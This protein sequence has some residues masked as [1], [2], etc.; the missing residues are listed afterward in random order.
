M[1]RNKMGI[2]TANGRNPNIDEM[3]RLGAD[4]YT[5]IYEAQGMEQARA[6]RSSY[7]D[8]LILM[9]HYLANWPAHDPIEWADY[10]ANKYEEYSGITRHVTF[11]N[12]QNLEAEG[13]GDTKEWYEAINKWNKVVILKLR[14]K[15]PAMVI[16]APA[17]AYGNRDDEDLEG[18][19]WT[20]Y[21]ICRECIEMCDILNH[22]PYWKPGG[23]G[24]FSKWYGLR[25][26][27]AREFFLDMPIFLDEAGNFASDDSDF[28]D[29]IERY[30]RKLYEYPYILGVTFFIWAD[31]TGTNVVNSWQRARHLSSLVTRLR[32]ADFPKVEPGEVPK[33]KR[34][35]DYPRPENGSWRGI[36]GSAECHHRWA[37]RP[38]GRNRWL[39]LIQS[40]KIGWYKVLDDGS[41]DSIPLIELLRGQGMM[42]IVRLFRGSTFPPPL[43]PKWKET[44]KR[45]VNAGAPY[46]EAVN[47]PRHEDKPDGLETVVDNFIHNADLIHEA[48]GIPLFPSIGI[49]HM[50]GIFKMIAAKG[51]R[52]IFERGAGVAIHNYTLNHPLNYPYDA[53]NKEGRPLTDEEW[54]LGE[55]AWRRRSRE[56]INAQRERDKNP[57]ATYLDDIHNW[58]GFQAAHAALRAAFGDL[59]DDIPIFTTEGGPEVGDGQDGRYPH[60]TP[61]IHQEVV[62]AI[63]KMMQVHRFLPELFPDGVPEELEEPFPWYFAHCHWLIADRE[64]GHDGGWEP[65]A[66][67]GHYWDAQFGLHG[68]LP[69]VEALA[70]LPL[71]PEEEVALV[72]G[73]FEGGFR[74][75]GA[76]EVI[77]AYGWEPWWDTNKPTDVPNP[78]EPGYNRRPEFKPDV[79]RPPSGTCQK[80][81]NTHATHNAGLYQQVA[82]F[83][84]LSRTVPQG[85]SELGR[86]GRKVTFR[87]KAYVWSSQYD[88][89]AE[90]REPGE[91]KISIGIDPFGGT[92]ALADT[93]VWSEPKEVYDQ[94]TGLSVSTVAQADEIT[95]FLRGRCRWRVKNNNSYWD[96]CRLT[97]EPEEEK[98]WLI[99]LYE[100]LVALSRKIAKFL[101][102]G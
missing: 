59:A 37:R 50:E 34:L 42:P 83:G 6:I 74:M 13:G 17:F 20:G 92:D 26:T 18:R 52:D 78:D 77:V 33:R 32:E 55:W 95:V 23:E 24:I 51:R 35:A 28:G 93:V 80:F 57:G 85:L 1:R 56:E 21:E 70:S 30:V 72:N 101:P 44:V 69:A 67:I 3:L 12:E 16:H 94:W 99:K 89:L 22:H 4:S 84:E 11:A 98:P 31:P 10:V 48:G 71:E 90:S 46:F 61:W 76:P 14:A 53:V 2:Y 88:D 66:W 7:P 58:L 96:Q 79:E 27:L 29:Q 5:C 49:N 45:L 81:F 73:D 63:N 38:E 39:P 36:H 102:W 54:A 75:V 15:C 100:K 25:F 62:I 82:G 97:I 9:R 68:Q 91:Y 60:T 41:C 65:Q 19:G 86:A 40:L 47:E 8:A 64:M 87:A 43:E